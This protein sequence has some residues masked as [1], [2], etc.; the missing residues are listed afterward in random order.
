[1]KTFFNWVAKTFE[2]DG[3]PSSKRCTLF[4]ITLLYCYCN[5]MFERLVNDKEWL[6]YQL[7]LNAVMILLIA[8]VA[9][10]ENII[11]L[12]QTIKGKIFKVK[13]KKE[14]PT[15]DNTTEAKQ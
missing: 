12:V 4:A 1:M 10:F 14:D 5:Y 9:T 13:T 6:Y 3:Q 8:G 7:C 15:T 11:N 2:K